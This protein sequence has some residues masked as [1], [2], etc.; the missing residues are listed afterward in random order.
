MYQVP[1]CCTFWRAWIIVHILLTLPSGDGKMLM[2]KE[3]LTVKNLTATSATVV[4]SAQFD[5]SIEEASAAYR[6]T[7]SH[8]REGYSR[9]YI[10]SDPNDPDCSLRI[11]KCLLGN[12][13]P[14]TV[15]SV[16]VTVDYITDVNSSVMGQ[17]ELIFSTLPTIAAKDGADG[18]EWVMMVAVA[19]AVA[20]VVIILIT[21]VLCRV[22]HCCCWRKANPTV[23]TA[24]SSR[25]VLRSESHATRQW[26]KDTF[27]GIDS[28]FIPTYDQPS[29]SS[30]SS[31]SADKQHCYLQVN[32]KPN[33]KQTRPE[34]KKK[35]TL[36]VNS[37][38]PSPT[39]SP[40]AAPTITYINTESMHLAPQVTTASGQYQ[41]SDPVMLQPRPGHETS[42]QRSQK[43]EVGKAVPYTNTE[44]V[45]KLLGSARRMFPML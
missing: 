30:T 21:A 15:Y 33:N 26:V 6:L 25:H 42:A 45:N 39:T 43:R 37:G 34:T 20:G 19:P 32:K 35:P 11:S 44:D 40:P 10:F 2:R 38:K 14:D 36:I 31:L 17:A 18:I 16:T 5:M 22:C 7:I 3:S 41:N 13:V 4:W 1:S 23:N 29:I 12:L 24:T 27:N 8:Q 9:N 28:E